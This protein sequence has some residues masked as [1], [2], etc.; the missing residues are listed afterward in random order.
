MKNLSPSHPDFM[1]GKPPLDEETRAAASR[2]G[3]SENE[4]WGAIEAFSAPEP[5]SMAEELAR[6]TSFGNGWRP[7]RAR[8]NIRPGDVIEYLD[9]DDRWIELLH[10]VTPPHACDGAGQ[11]FRARYFDFGENQW[12]AE[13]MRRDPGRI[14]HIIGHWDHLGKLSWKEAVGDGHERKPNTE[15][16]SLPKII[17]IGEK[18]AVGINV[19]AV[20][21]EIQSV[22]QLPLRL[23]LGDLDVSSFNRTAKGWHVFYRD[24]DPE[25]YCEVTFERPADTL[26]IRQSYSGNDEIYIG[27]GSSFKAALQSYSQFPDRWHEVLKRRASGLGNV[28]VPTLPKEILTGAGFPDGAFYTIF[29]PIAVHR[30]LEACEALRAIQ[31]QCA[32]S[33]SIAAILAESF[34]TYFEDDG[35]MLGREPEEDV[36]GPCDAESLTLSLLEDTGFPPLSVEN[37]GRRWVKLHRQH[38]TLHI[39]CLF[40]DAHRILQSLSKA[41]LISNDRECLEFAAL[42][43]PTGAQEQLQKLAF[44]APN[45]SRRVVYPAASFMK[46]GAGEPQ[47]S[48][49][50]ELAERAADRLCQTF[51]DNLAAGRMRG[52]HNPSS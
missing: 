31:A 1:S 17:Q 52:T 22:D 46:P 36:F 38:Y 20:P 21:A 43:M 2:M 35:V 30:L 12:S 10:V 25:V 45:K 18:S 26:V 40:R 5:P 16:V 37:E 3:L 13:V 50:V 47:P 48:P 11:A 29:V 15:T 4:V 49:V 7:Y 44:S 9:N 51:L 27:N 8:R 34:V 24:A 28:L 41:Q 19:F 14:L 32:C 42:V 6:S 39:D 33:V 23:F